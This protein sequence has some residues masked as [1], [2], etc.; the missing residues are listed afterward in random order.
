[1]EANKT[2]NELFEIAEKAVNQLNKIIADDKHSEI[3][4]QRKLATE[5]VEAANAAY[6]K[7]SN[8]IFLAAEYPFF[9]AIKTGYID[10]LRLNVTVNKDTGL[11]EA[12]IETGEEVVDLRAL[13]DECKNKMLA[14]NGKWIYWAEKFTFVMAARVNADIGG[15]S[16]KFTQ[17][18]KIS[19][20]A[21]DCDIGAT[22]T[23][24]AQ[25]LKQLQAIIDGILFEDNGEG[26]NVYK[27]LSKD[28]NYINRVMTKRGKGRLSVS[29]PRQ[30]TMIRLVTEVLHRI[31]T[32]GAYTSEYEMIKA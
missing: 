25:M 26:L 2:A 15:D 18:Y 6:R 30:S 8:A 9:E 13:E 14:H 11:E 27:A 32:G 24:N 12:S 7:E 23:S 31:V 17:M 19:Q 3:K 28:V 4:S 20:T 29:M 10:C 5:A 16:K 1:M 22:P 21:R